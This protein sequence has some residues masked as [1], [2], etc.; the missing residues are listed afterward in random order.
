MEHRDHMTTR[1]I[2]PL[3]V[4]ILGVVSV[5][6]CY[7]FVDRPVATFLRNH[8]FC[9]DA[10]RHWPPFLS[11]WLGYFLAVAILGVVA[12]RIWRPGGRL[13]TLLLAIAANL[14]VTT[15]IKDVLK[16]IFGRAWPETWYAHSQS[17]LMDGVYGFHP[18][19]LGGQYGAF[20]SGHAA[21]T[22]AVISI[23]W[24]SLPPWRWL[25]AVAGGLVCVALVGLNYHFV[26][27]VIAGAM[28]GS[29]TGFYTTQIFHLLPAGAREAAER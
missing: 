16:W 14:V 12:W 9:S 24:L 26:G 5:A 6:L 15:V 28:L 4:L 2:R 18:F 3:L 11:K 21:G 27:D 22:F 13:Q 17:L 1:F 29:T 20:P 7:Y 23:L 10:V 25:C 8:R 19:H